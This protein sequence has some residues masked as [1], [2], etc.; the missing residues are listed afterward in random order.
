MLLTLKN[1]NDDDEEEE[2][3]RRTGRERQGKWCDRGP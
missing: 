2:Q 3:M 1:N